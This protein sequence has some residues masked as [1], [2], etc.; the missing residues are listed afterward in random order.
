MILRFLQLFALLLLLLQSTFILSSCKKD[1]PVEV[2]KDEPVEVPDT[3]RPGRRDYVWTI[4]TLY[5]PMATIRCVWGATPNDVWAV[6]PGGSDDYRLY[7]YDG[8]KW[9]VYQKEFIDCWG[10]VITGFSRDNVWM[11]GTEGKI[12]HYDGTKWS[13]N[14]V[15]RVDEHKYVLRIITDMCGISP[16]NIYACGVLSEIVDDQTIHTGFLLHYDGNTWKEIYRGGKSAQFIRIKE[17]Y[18]KVYILEYVDSK[19]DI[20]EEGLAFYELSDGRIKKIYSKSVKDGTW[21][22]LSSVGHRVYFCFEK[23]VALYRQNE[24]LTQFTV[25][26]PAFQNDIFGRNP[27]DI[28]IPMRDGLAHYNGEDIKYLFRHSTDF[29]IWAYG[30]LVFD[31]EIFC[32]VYDFSSRNNLVLHGKLK[33]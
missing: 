32:A 12:W 7:H 30:E 4:D 27:K 33:E 22:G 2:K 25:D 31:K 3:S 20:S 11:V 13:W 1:S 5:M 24:F 23:D 18:G 9:K 15:Y 14:F 19:K 28:F 21:M 10:N 17:E 16:D 6:G 8:K 26:E 29:T